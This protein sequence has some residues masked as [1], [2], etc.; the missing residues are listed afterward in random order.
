MIFLFIAC[1]T[2]AKKMEQD[3]HE[4][5]EQNA[6]LEDQIAKMETDLAQM[7][8]PVEDI[9][10]LFQMAFGVDAQQAGDLAAYG[11]STGHFVA[12]PTFEEVSIFDELE[13]VERYDM[14]I[15]SEDF[16]RL[17]DGEYLMS[18]VRAVPKRSEDSQRLSRSRT[19]LDGYR[20]SGIRRNSILYRL[21]I[22]NGD[23]VMAVN[24]LPITSPQEALEIQDEVKTAA[25]IAVLISRRNVPRLM[26]YTRNEA[27]GQN[28]ENAPQ[29]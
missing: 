5:Q 3:I 29:E 12:A 22:K 13:R 27:D 1:M 9:T 4:L 8:Q 16:E 21:G 24:G 17:S 25:E 7:R 11:Q 14:I 23:I 15:E 19:S 2:T 6:V 26:V 10:R 28:E 18:N 20:L